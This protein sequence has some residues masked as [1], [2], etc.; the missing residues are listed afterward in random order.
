MRLS[1]HDHCEQTHF[2]QRIAMVDD[3]DETVLSHPITS[4][5]YLLCLALRGRQFGEI[6]DGEICILN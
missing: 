1:C 2:F 5:R 3:V 4:D 6:N